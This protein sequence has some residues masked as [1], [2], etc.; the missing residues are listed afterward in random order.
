MRLYLNIQASSP[1]VF[2]LELKNYYIVYHYLPKLS[3]ILLHVHPSHSSK[4][5]PY[6]G[7]I[8]FLQYQNHT[9]ACLG[10]L[11]VTV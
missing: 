6:G 10:N 8:K 2:H 11:N 1:M 7:T 9:L 3:F 4:G 5:R